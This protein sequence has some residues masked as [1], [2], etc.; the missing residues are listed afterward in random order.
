MKKARLIV[1]QNIIGAKSV[2]D[3]KSLDAY[4]ESPYEIFDEQL[5]NNE[6]FEIL[7]SKYCSYYANM[8]NP[9]FKV[10]FQQSTFSPR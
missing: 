1:F 7:E 5:S 9:N 10:E 6:I 4:Y 8:F 2:E 3:L